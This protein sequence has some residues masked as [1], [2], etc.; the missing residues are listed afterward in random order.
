MN[1][2]K[3]WLSPPV[4]DNAEK[5]HQAYLLHFILLALIA[6]PIPFVTYLLIR[7]PEESDRALI[8]I[9]VSEIIHIILFIILRRGH[10]QIASFLQVITI[11]QFLAI[12]S[13]TSSSIYG[14]AY[15]LGNA[16]VITI[17]GILLGGRGALVLTLLIILEGAILV[18]A[19]VQG[20][21]P[22][23]ILDDALPTWIVSVVLFAVVASLQNLAA[24]EVRAAL[25]RAQ[26]SEERYRLI[27]EV[28]SDYTFSTEFNAKGNISGFWAGG[29]FE[30]ITGYTIKEY[31]NLESWRSRLHPDDFEKDAQNTLDLKQNR[32]F[33]SDLRLY[34]KD[35]DLR[36]IRIY[37]N[38]VWNQK[39]DRLARV[40]G[41]VQDITEQR[42]AEELEQ[43]RRLMMEKVIQLGKHVTEVSDLR[44]TLERIWHGV[45]DELD[46]DRL[47]IFLHNPK[48]NFMQG[49]LGT[50]NDGQIVEEWEESFPIT[51]GDMFH[52][53]IQK[54]DG[55]HFTHNYDIEESVP[56]GDEMYGVKDFAAVAGWA[57]DKPVAII[58]ADNLPSGRSIT[59]EKLEALRLFGGYAGLAIENARLHTALQNELRLQKEAEERE[60]H[61]RARLEQ[62]ILLGQQVTKVSD[63]RST[64]EKIWNGIHF[65][66]GFDRLAIFLYDQEAN[67][68]HGT[69]GTDNDGRLVEEWEYVQTLEQQK[70]SSFLRALEQP[71]GLFFT[72]SFGIDFEIPEGHKMHNVQDFVAVSAWAGEKPVAIITVD[73]LPSGRSITHAHLESLRL[74]C[75][76]AG[77]AI[78]NARLN[79][80]LQDELEHRQTLIREL[81]AKNAE[82][83]RFT[84]TVS[85]DL[86]SPLV[87]ITGFLGY[88]ERD[89]LDGNVQKI[90]SDIERIVR[91]AEKM[92]A[93]LNDLLELS[94]VGRLINSPQNVPFGD[95]VNEALENVRGRLES[96]KINVKVHDDLPT[97]LGD[98]VRL[99]EVL[100]NLIDN[101]AK[102]THTSPNPSI[103]IGTSGLDQE[104]NHIYFVRDNG[105]G[106]QP[107]F[108][109]RIFGLFNKLDQTVEGT[110]IGLTLVKR[111]IEV[112]GGKIW[113][114]S[115][116]G[117]GATFYFT[118]PGSKNE[119]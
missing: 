40:V 2:L 31:S 19:E 92:Q 24:R 103:E 81:E 66:L 42:R 57:S 7:A 83:E 15:T 5:T 8:L 111:I 65:E 43:R 90:R 12:A 77:L 28:T 55:F 101:A 35:G 69:F 68:V 9:A 26:T 39:E 86:K 32:S 116:L 67:T 95:I 53:V 88:L 117:K 115:E 13:I 63:L 80:A 48:K 16:M 52:R 76:Y 61:R 51:V 23:D 110:G 20:W 62:V 1:T 75:G 78:E 70:P 104:A 45:H 60:V 108:Q 107:E 72:R 99:V 11:W 102:F 10:V 109:E 47:A 73:N 87:T 112:H 106:I 33:V 37:A 38:P 4:F 97:V 56:E 6:I 49:T 96:N 17:A 41:A 105:I 74:F 29:A 44:T 100:Q 79:E 89:A 84:Y 114:E 22:P 71:N 98:K 36:W 54:P 93:L 91:A 25:N 58:V 27:S 59:D 30:K 3:A 46:F 18:Y 50:N 82:L 118:L 94:R 14:V 21:D 34:R 113:V 64:L 85:H 119:E